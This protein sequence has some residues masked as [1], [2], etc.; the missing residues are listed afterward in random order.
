MLEHKNELF[1]KIIL[2]ENYFFPSLL[3]DLYIVDVVN[4]TARTKLHTKSASITQQTKR[5]KGKENGTNTCVG[6]VLI[7]L[8][9]KVSTVHCCF[10]Q[11][12]KCFAE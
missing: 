3:V 2:S 10:K 11:F 5:H 6:K 4:G 1:K 9:A 8:L 12:P 7:L